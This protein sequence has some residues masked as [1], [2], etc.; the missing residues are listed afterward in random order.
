MDGR[1]HSFDE[2]SGGSETVG[3]VRDHEEVQ[4]EGRVAS[5][6]AEEGH[7]VG[8]TAPESAGPVGDDGADTGDAEGGQGVQGGDKL[9]G[10]GRRLPGCHGTGDDPDGG[11]SEDSGE[12][13]GIVTVEGSAGR[14]GGGVVDPGEAESR[15]V[16]HRHVAAVP[17]GEGGHIAGPAVQFGDRRQ[18][19]FGQAILVQTER[20]EGVS[21]TGLGGR[22]REDLSEVGEIACR[23]EDGTL[24]RR[25][26]PDRMQMGVDKPGE[27]TGSSRLK[28]A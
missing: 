4:V 27:M 3:A 24:Y 9:R 2:P 28:K 8:W 18:P 20:D 23:A 6:L 16:R 22:G 11:L 21:G 12:A 14:I 17:V 1:A 13:P 5:D 10:G 25:C 19:A 15:S 7:L 26:V